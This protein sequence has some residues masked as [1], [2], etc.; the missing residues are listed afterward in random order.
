ML[1]QQTRDIPRLRRQRHGWQVLCGYLFSFFV[2]E[3]ALYVDKQP[4]RY[5]HIKK[6]VGTIHVSKAEWRCEVTNMGLLLVTM[7]HI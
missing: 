5:R 3:R 7:R 1:S 4:S 2:C 6:H